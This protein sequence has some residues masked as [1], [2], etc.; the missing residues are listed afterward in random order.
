MRNR[1]DTIIEVL[2]A[3]TIFSLVAVGSMVLMNRGVAM[4]QQSL[5]TT[6]VRQQIDAQAEMLR[7]VH[8]QA[9]AALGEQR[10]ADAEAL[11]Q[12]AEALCGP[13]DERL[14]VRLAISATWVTFERHGLDAVEELLDSCH[15]L[16][17][18]GVDR[19]RRPSRKSLAQEAQ[20]GC[21]EKSPP[22]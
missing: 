2:L 7:F 8:D 11:L 10:T 21:G 5:E 9:R 15:A 16:M 20:D 3:V 12:Q 18:H 1:G 14:R 19:Y 6:L 17:N 22:I 4:A 13:G